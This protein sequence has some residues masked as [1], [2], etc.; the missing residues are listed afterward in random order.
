MKLT[1]M[2]CIPCRGG[3]P[4]LSQAEIDSLLLQVEGWQVIAHDGVQQLSR[5][6]KFKNFA[7]ALDFAN[8]VGRL[9]EQQNHHPALLVEWGQVTVR[10]WTHVIGGLHQND[11][12]SAAKTDHI[13]HND[14]T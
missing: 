3:Q 8:A 9:A 12:I 11:F 5:R 10:W 7:L 2:D 14:T 4:K 13:F 6:Y 1:E